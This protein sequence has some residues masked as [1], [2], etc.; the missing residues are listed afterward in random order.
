ETSV[1]ADHLARDREALGKA[2]QRAGVTDDATAVTISF[3]DRSSLASGAQ[4][5]AQH[6][7]GQ[8]QQAGSRSNGQS[9]PGYQGGTGNP[10]S[11][12]QDANAFGG[13]NREQRPAQ[14]DPQPVVRRGLVV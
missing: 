8:E 1:I 7:G 14:G 9:Q 3:V 12:R 2:L 4:S 11:G 10:S 6:Y 13:G 5:S